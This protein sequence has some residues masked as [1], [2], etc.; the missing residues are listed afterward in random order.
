M[1][2]GKYRLRDDCKSNPDIELQIEVVDGVATCTK[3][4]YLL[5]WKLGEH[6]HRDDLIPESWERI[7][8]EDT[9]FKKGDKV[10]RK[11][12]MPFSN[13]EFKITV[14]YITRYRVYFVETGT[15]D[16]PKDLE[17]VEIS[18]E[19]STPTPHKYADV[20]KAWA[21]G[22]EVQY[23][24]WDTWHDSIFPSFDP[25]LEWRIKPENPNQDRILEIEKTITE[26]QNELE[27]LKTS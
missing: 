13:E 5:Y 27:E 1:E 18:S 21:D 10:K 25:D 15:W 6:I 17:L 23:L 22:Y 8:N 26:L 16:Y 19:E 7:P 4:E 12:G 11:D 20:I 3:V 9:T 14:D 24:N 2:N